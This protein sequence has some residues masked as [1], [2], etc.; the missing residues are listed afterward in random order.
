MKKVR[1]RTAI[2]ILLGWLLS[3]P[4]R[5]RRIGKRL[6][7]AVSTSSHSHHGEEHSNARQASG[8]RR[9]MNEAAGSC[10]SGRN[11]WRLDGWLAADE[12]ADAAVALVNPGATP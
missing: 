12:S 1:V 11:R 2:A 6:R 3:R 7:H 4:S 8:D 10:H 5:R 9:Q